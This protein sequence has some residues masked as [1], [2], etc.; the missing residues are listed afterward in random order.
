LN[1][2]VA[3]LAFCICSVTFNRSSYQ[4]APAQMLNYDLSSLVWTLDSPRFGIRLL[5]YGQH[6]S[7]KAIVDEARFSDDEGYHSI[8]AAERL[9]VPCP[10]NQDWSKASPIAFEELALLS[11]VAALTERVKLGTY[12]LLAPLRNPLVLARQVTTLDV[13]SNGRVILG[14]GLGW[15]KEEFEA[16]GVS[17]SERGA[18]TDETIQFLRK[19]WSGD[20]PAT[21]EG[22]FIKLGPSLFEPAPVQKSIPIWIGGMSIPALKRAGKIGDGWVPNAM[23]KQEVMRRSM[24]TISTE[25]KKNGRPATAVT[26]SC[27]LTLRGTRAERPAIV[28]SI[29]SLRELGVQLFIIDFGGDSAADFAEKIRLFSR[30]VMRSF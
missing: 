16:S 15:M 25:A 12:V 28:R 19:I 18:R 27:R 3:H 7:R 17:M 11:Y 26:I 10:P 30:E 20:E 2:D 24:K 22:T 21:F 1:I 14:L 13:L 23:V 29:E 4:R 6:A 8:W 9:L 5:S